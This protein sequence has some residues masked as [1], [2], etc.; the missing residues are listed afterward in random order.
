MLILVALFAV[1]QAQPAPRTGVLQGVVTTQ[2]TVNLPGVQVTVTDSS[3][4]QVTQVLTG[5]DGHFSVVG[6]VPGRYKVSAALVSFVT[7]TVNADVAAGRVSDL[8]IDLPI[9]GIATTVDVVAQNP[10]VSSEGTV[11][12]TETIS[13]KEI[14]TFAA[15][16]GLQ[17][18]MRLLASVIQA[19]NGVSIRGGRPSQAGVQL[20]VSTMVDPSTGL[21]RVTLP[22]DAIE[23]VSVLPNP[24]AV[25][26]GRFS[27]GVV[28]IQTR[29]AGDQWRLRIND[30]DPTF[31]THRGSPVEIIGLGR[32]APRVEF[33]GPVV[34]DK[35]FVEQAMQFVYS[36]MDVPSLPEDLLHTQTSFSSFTRVDANLD[37]RHSLI[38]TFGW[39]PGKTHW[40]L[41]GT[42]TP[43]EATVDTHVRAQ[44]IAATERAVWTDSLFGETTVHVHR[45]ATD[46]LPQGAAPMQ[47]LPDTTIGNFF[48][49]QHRQTATYQV[50]AT[51]SGS[52][53]TKQG[54]HL[55]KGGVDLLRNDYDGT[56][57][58]RPVLI[59]RADGS[60]IRSLTYTPN[61]TAQSQATTDVALFAQD[62]YQRN[63]RW[64][65]EFGGRV[66]RDGI[67]DR[68]NV[69]PRVGSAVLLDKA[70]AA[71]VRGGFGLF[72]ERTPSTVGAFAQ[73]PSVVDQRY[74]LNG[75]TPSGPAV[76][77]VP[78]VQDLQTAR[79]RT[80]DLGFDYRFNAM[81]SLHLG[82]LDR[83]GRDELLVNPVQTGPATGQL[84]LS[85]SGNSVYRGAEAA[86]HFNA[87]DR[88]DVNVSYT[89]SRARTDLNAMSNYYDTIMWP[90]LGRNEYAPAPTDAPNRL[91]ARG[92][93]TPWK[94]WLVIGILDWRTG[95]PWSPTTD[96]LDYV[97]PRNSL[98]FPNYV[99]LEAGLERHVK[100][101]KFR[102]WLGVRV[103][104]A[105]DAFLPVDVQS[106]L[107]SANFGTFYN[108]EYPQIRIVLRFER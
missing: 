67:L 68:Y 69:T 51:L 82:Y 36:A 49:E 6:L 105:L 55:F 4:K 20:G 46:V 88:A 64:Y 33:G 43:P 29:R 86:V 39:F 71:V 102:P 12:Q 83:D 17:A 108:S 79:S 87:G 15:S 62:R 73:F 58:S 57:L 14:D 7:T 11:A 47:L 101:L 59:E 90:A 22:D 85:S 16:G 40:D 100:I 107:G 23:S 34:K 97:S 21:S 19:P 5:E 60:L 70:G 26:F 27:S 3:D 2:S 77:F 54:S 98:R 94:N 99:R 45:F 92:R 91:L 80:W 53:T 78:D 37:Q 50:I 38:G 13:G 103:W 30:I 95:F 75:T 25:E 1:L 24:Y 9:E 106:N 66:D 41:L 61:L 65:V 44:E 32:E 42:F 48:N 35:L 8:A 10:V 81:W 52:K 104:N 72:F 96:A 56:S 28:V 18:T 76:T 84:L 31:R 63:A 74:Q 89:R 93:F